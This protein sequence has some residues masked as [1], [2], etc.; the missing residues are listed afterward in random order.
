MPGLFETGQD[1]RA[2]FVTRI[3]EQAKQENLTLTDF[4]VRYL[5]LS[6]QGQD[7]AACDMLDRLKGKAFDE[8]DLRI[9]GLAWRAYEQDTGLCSSAGECYQ[10]AIR[11]LA[12]V[13]NYP[14][15]GMFVNCI[16]LKTSPEELK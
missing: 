12:N 2:Y 10:K 9:S 6:E 4:E 11:A 8:F 16:A 5:E 7:K 13:D 15:L 3:R 14:N 1:P